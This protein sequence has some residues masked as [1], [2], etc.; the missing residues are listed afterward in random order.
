MLHIITPLYRFE[1]LEQIYNSILINDDIT[2]HI[3]KSNRRE[4]LNNDFIKTDKRIKI[5]NCD[6]EDTDTTIKRNE[7][8]LHENMYIKYKECEEQKVSTILEIQSLL[9]LRNN[10]YPE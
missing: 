8:I 2:W 10:T 3:S 1:N 7:V 4:E 5:Y 6:C 9:N